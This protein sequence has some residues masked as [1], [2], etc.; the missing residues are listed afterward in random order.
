MVV[1]QGQYSVIQGQ[2]CCGDDSCEVQT[3]YQSGMDYFDFTHNRTRFDDPVNGMIVSLF[4]PIYKEMLVDSTNTCQAYCPIEEDLYP[5]SVDANATYQ[6][7]KSI[8]GK[9]Y[10]DWQYQDKEFGIVFETDDTFVDPKSQ[11]PYME[12]DQ[13][14]PFGQAIGMES[15]TYNTF[16]P[17]TPDPSHFDIKN[18]DNC[19]MDQNCGQ[20]QRQF[21]RR[22]WGQWRTWAKY[23]GESQAEK[24]EQLLRHMKQY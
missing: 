17:G 1:Y 19:P 3:Q 6:G 4:N 9:L 23:Y 14:T 20:S 24:A 18:V 11:L 13:L 7:Q 5:Y 15:S 12:V 16:T 10:D 22:R 2:Y 21:V 8:N